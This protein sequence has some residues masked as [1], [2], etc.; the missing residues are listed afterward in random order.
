MLLNIVG[1]QQSALTYYVGGWGVS[2]RIWE[3]ARARCFLLFDGD[4]KTTLS[5]RG[6][7]RLARGIIEGAR[8]GK[9]GEESER[10]EH[11]VITWSAEGAAQ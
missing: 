6:A 7:P 1:V 2:G 9:E 5:K 4:S 10:S 11:H 8:G 3:L